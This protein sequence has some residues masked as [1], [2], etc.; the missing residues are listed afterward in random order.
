MVNSPFGEM[1]R[2]EPMISTLIRRCAATLLCLLMLSQVSAGWAASVDLEAEMGIS[3]AVTYVRTVPLTVTLTNNETDETG[4]VWID[5]S[6]S[7]NQYD[8]Y[9][10]PVT[11]AAGATVQ[12][13]LPVLLTMRQD[14]YEVVWESGGKEKRSAVKISQVIDPTSI[15]VGLMEGQDPQASNL[16]SALST[17]KLANGESWSQVALTSDEFPRDVELLRFF[18]VLVVDGANL[19]ALDDA[20]RDAFDQWLR[21]GGLVL[22]GGGAQAAS[23]F[24]FFESYTGIRAGTAQPTQDI[25][26]RLIELMDLSA[27]A[28]QQ[29]VTLAS[30]EGASGKSIGDG[31]ADLC[32]VANGRVLTCSFSF[33]EKPLCGWLGRNAA[34]Q[35]LLT[36]CANDAYASLLEQRSRVYYSTD[37]AHRPNESLLTQ[38]AIPNSPGQWIPLAV[39]IAFIVLAGFAGYLILRRLDRREWMWA[40]VPALA[41]A[42]SLAVWGLSGS[43]EQREPVGVSSTVC[44]IHTDGSSDVYTSVMAAK[45]QAEPLTLSAVEGE[46]DLGPSVNYYYYNDD[47]SSPGVPASLRYRYTYGDSSSLTFAKVTAWQ[48][49]SMAFQGVPVK[50]FRGVS[51]VCEW[52]GEDLLFTLTNQSGHTLPGGVILCAYGYVTLPSVAPGQTTQARLRAQGSNGDVIDGV[53]SSD[54]MS[55]DLAYFSDIVN[56]YAYQVFGE[57]EDPEQNSLNSVRRMQLTALDT[58]R[59]VYAAF[60]DDLADMQLLADGQPVT[61]QAHVGML[62]VDLDYRS[63]NAQGQARF[64]PSSFQVYQAQQAQGEAPVATQSLQ[65][66]YRYYQLSAQPI[67]AI[68]I[69]A[70]PQDMD[71]DLFSISTPYQNASYRVSLYNFQTQQWDEHAVCLYNLSSGSRSRTSTLPDLSLYE[72]EGFLYARFVSADDTEYAEILSPRLIVEGSVQP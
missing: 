33:S 59:F 21:E 38:I 1:R 31:L 36:Y 4:T 39:I 49:V 47:P 6:R 52:D 66:E 71:V 24:P 30:L 70:L 62:A 41:V 48:P 14:S 61:R 64:L 34:L 51:G 2:M 42:A 72:S 55:D 13:T 50:D 20:Q 60:L 9:E 16:S 27:F 37:N 3:G 65:D 28:I 18:D 35:K 26:A 67:F 69:S 44:V 22:V 15:I 19:N 53:L 58:S 11:I 8:R 12:V 63:V 17:K 45:A 56:V 57:V 54:P 43:L 25:S 40:V 7:S 10:M 68:D 32:S 5:I 29:E 23:V 46:P